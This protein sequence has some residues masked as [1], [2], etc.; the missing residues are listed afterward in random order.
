MPPITGLLALSWN[1]ALSFGGLL[2]GFAV[3]LTG[4][5][6][7]ALLTPM[8]V[9]F[10]NVPASAAIGTDLVAS[11]VMKPVSGAVHWRKGTV[12][13]DIVKWLCIGSLP[14]AIIGAVIVGSLSENIKDNFLQRGIGVALLTAATTMTV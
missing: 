1:P 5:G 11:L 6:G 10:F 14:G 7:G 3:G 2:G 13:T 9:V 8:L 4:M 12:R